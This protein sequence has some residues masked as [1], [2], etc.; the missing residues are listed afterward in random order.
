MNFIYRSWNHYRHILQKCYHLILSNKDQ[1]NSLE[2]EQARNNLANLSQAIEEKNRSEVKRIAGNL[3]TFCSTH[4]KKP[5]YKS[6]VEILLALIIALAIASVVRAMWF[7]LYEIPTGSMRP[8]FKEQDHLTVS[9][10]QFG[11]NVPFETK[12]FTFDP[13]L[14]KRTGIVIFSGD[15]LP[16]IDSDTTYFG[17]FPYKKRYIKRMMG[18]PGDTVYFYGGKIY[19]IDKDGKEITELLDNPHLSKIEHIPFIS[20]IGHVDTPKKNEVLFKHMNIPM[21]RI[22]MTALGPK[23]EIFNGENWIE[24]DFK[25]SKQKHDEIKTFGDLWGIGNFGMTELLTLKELEREP[26]IDSKQPAKAELYLLIRHHPAMQRNSTML[27]REAPIIG[28]YPSLEKSVIPMDQA[29]LDA[30]MDN[31][32]TMRFVVKGGKAKRYSLDNNGFNA[33]SV[34][35]ENVPDGTYE[36]YYGKA[37]QVMTGG[38]LK[39]LGKDHPLYDHSPANVQKLYN[40][41]MNMD[42]SYEPTRSHPLMLPSRYTYFRDGDLYL[43]GAPVFKK[44]DA[45][46][47]NFLSAEEQKEKSGQYV[48]F[49]DQGAPLQN[50]QLNKE[51][52]QTFGLKIP[53]RNY[54]VLGDNHAMSSDSRIFGFVPEE[55]LQGVPEVVLW[56][57]SRFPNQPSYPTFVFPRWIVWCIM[58]LISLVWYGIYR[59]RMRRPIDLSKI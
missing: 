24:D 36:F 48:A 59:Y 32:Y 46:L 6:L 27:A 23:A 30:L 38:F 52:I 58:G 42:R 8:T 57:D 34:R 2:K 10:A 53:E 31:M 54:L 20:F 29:H 26:G 40:L 7:E 14:V 55:N 49:K 11:V 39:E 47:Q 37:Y 51:F 5:W 4:F 25:G 15:K 19:G 56:P 44:D 12:H 28:T 22:K 16:V 9:K 18:K 1:L 35:L 3:E 21:G 17:L 33:N 41:G 50:G 13:E 43:L 45:I